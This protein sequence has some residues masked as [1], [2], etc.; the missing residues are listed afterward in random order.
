MR[1]I[2]FR[3]KRIDNGEWAEGS[4]VLP[5]CELNNGLGVFCEGRAYICISLNFIRVSSYEHREFELGSFVEVDPKTVGQYTEF[6]DMNGKKV[7]EGDICL[8]DRNIGW[9]IDS[10]RFV[11]KFLYDVGAWGGETLISEIDASQFEMCEIIGN[12]HDNPE[13][14]RED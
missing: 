2:L 8:C 7:F 14:L 5:N 3:G 13:L 11:I 4:L 6:T 1:E 10:Q 12:I 9:L